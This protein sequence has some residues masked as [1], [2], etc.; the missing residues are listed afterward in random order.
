MLTL[1]TTALIALA[2]AP[3]AQTIVSLNLD[4]MSIYDKSVVFVFTNVLKTYRVGK[5]NSFQL[6]LDHYKD[7][8]ICPMHCLLH[9]IKT[10]EK[11]RK[12][13]QVF[14][15]Y[16]TYSKIS[17]STIARWLKTI[18]ELSGIDTSVFKSHSYRSAA[19]SAAFMKG[20]SI[21]SILKTANWSSDKN[22][23]KFYYRTVEHTNDSFVDSMFRK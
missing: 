2:S 1:K 12:S 20:C 9:Y 14:V 16:V 22:F 8:K 18:L 6:Q 21:K 5:A 4:N 3:R 13:R 17:T 15:S 23:Y 11:L 19:V 7:E 10:T